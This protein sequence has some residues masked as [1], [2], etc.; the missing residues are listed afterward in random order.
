M[1]TRTN[2]LTEIAKS[3]ADRLA[4]RCGSLKRV[5]S[6]GVLALEALSPDERERFMAAAIGA[7]YQTK[8]EVEIQKA[9]LMLK[10]NMADA[11]VGEIIRL[12]SPEMLQ[13][14]QTIRTQTAPQVTPKKTRRIGRVERMG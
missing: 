9:L 8:P 4:A 2:D 11:P 1:A 10:D 6:A 12:L 7:S 3:T 13:F 14:I 5:L